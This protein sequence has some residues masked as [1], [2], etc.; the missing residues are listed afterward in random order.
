[1]AMSVYVPAA[2]RPIPGVV[3]Y[4]EIYQESGPVARLAAVLA[5][6]GYAMVWGRQDPHIPDDAPGLIHTRLTDAGVS[7]TGHEFNAE[8][9][10]LRAEGRRYDPPPARIAVGL[11][12][13]LFHRQLGG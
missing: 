9:A 10:F 2:G 3:L 5:G 13:D 8:H 12:L 7:F 6:H 11:A 4:S 1:M